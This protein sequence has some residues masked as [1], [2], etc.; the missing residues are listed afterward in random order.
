ML[1]Y[2]N[3]HGRCSA[4]GGDPSPF[5]TCVCDKGWGSP[6]DIATEKD[7]LCMLRTC[8]KGRATSDLP[9]SKNEAHPMRECSNN[10][11]CDRLTGKCLCFASWAGATCQRK[12]CPNECSGHGHEWKNGSVVRYEGSASSTTWDESIGVGC[13]C[14][15]SWAFFGADCSLRRCPSH[16]DPMTAADETDCANCSNRGTCDYGNGLCKCFKGH[17]GVACE[18]QTTIY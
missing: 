6:D 18:R 9:F 17:T 7:A 8:P 5:V 14:D 16:D 2:C 3:G 11:V 13:L 1:N 12:L 4:G 10:G 15:S